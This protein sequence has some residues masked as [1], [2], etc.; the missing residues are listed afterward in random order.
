[1]VYSASVLNMDV[2]CQGRKEKNERIITIACIIKM[3]MAPPSSCASGMIFK[4]FVKTLNNVS[5]DMI[6]RFAVALLLRSSI[7]SFASS[8]Q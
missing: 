8:E 3:R 7:D 4:Y 2:I 5:M 1:M 6:N